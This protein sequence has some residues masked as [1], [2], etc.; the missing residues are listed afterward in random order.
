M[1]ELQPESPLYVWQTVMKH[2]VYVCLFDGFCLRRDG[3]RHNALRYG[4]W[5]RMTCLRISWRPF[6]IHRYS[7]ICVVVVSALADSLLS[8]LFIGVAWLGVVILVS[9]MGHQVS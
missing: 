5:S 3:G 1:F 2:P 9:T 7:R 6:F 8:V 4:T